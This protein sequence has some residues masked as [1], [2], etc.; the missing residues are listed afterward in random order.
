MSEKLAHDAQQCRDSELIE[1]GTTY[2]D[3]QISYL[4][5]MKLYFRALLILLRS[6]RPRYYKGHALWLFL[7]LRLTSP[8]QPCIPVLA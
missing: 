4:L 2:A 1:A 7:L 8:F 3:A 5:G 6:V